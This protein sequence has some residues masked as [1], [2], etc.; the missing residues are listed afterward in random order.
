[1]R[2]RMR[3]LL[4]AIMV[5]ATPV[6]ARAELFAV[7]FLGLK[8]GGGTSIADLEFAADKKK[9]TMGGAVMQID[10][11]LIGYEAA[12]GYIPGYLD[13]EDPALG[14]LAKSGSFVVDFTGSAIIA[15]PPR[16]TGGGLR[17]YAAVGAGLT[18]VQA[19]DLLQLFQTR[20][21]VPVAHIG[22][23]AI[24]LF[25][26]NVGVRFDYRYTRSLLTDDGTL[27]TV[28][29]RISYSRFTVGLFLRL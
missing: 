29:R 13:G 20:R 24:G 27:R 9:F 26:N 3:V 19:A 4:A 6:A 12:F 22:G 15:M 10:E 8:F 1:M 25:T 14:P 23:G 16:F 11:G 7:P 28:G 18:H 5:A 17:P 21:T 2:D